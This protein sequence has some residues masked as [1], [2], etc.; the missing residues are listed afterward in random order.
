MTNIILIIVYAVLLLIIYLFLYKRLNYLNKRHI[1]HVW[2]HYLENRK[3]FMLVFIFV[4]L[5]ILFFV[6]SFLILTVL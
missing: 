6:N 3:K 4:L 2:C 1:E 5:L